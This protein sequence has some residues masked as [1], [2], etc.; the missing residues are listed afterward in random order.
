MAI[1]QPSGAKV[2]HDGKVVTLAQTGIEG[3]PVMGFTPHAGY[4]ADGF[5]IGLDL[6]ID[7]NESGGAIVRDG[8]LTFTAT[9]GFAVVA[10][11]AGIIGCK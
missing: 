1:A 3:A 5:G 8:T 7:A 4:A 11:V 6:V 2:I 10:P 9:D